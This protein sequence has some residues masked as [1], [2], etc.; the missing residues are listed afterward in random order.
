MVT[1]LDAVDRELSAIGAA[2]G[3]ELFELTQEIWKLLTH[4][5]PE[6]RGDELVGRLLDASIEENVSTLLH[7]F[8]HGTPAD[9]ADAPAGPSSTPAGWLSAGSPSSR[10]SARTASGTAASSPGA[11]RRSPSPSEI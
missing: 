2:A 7:V 11:W 10:S 3:A 9:Q 1:S 5:I 8:E 6:L 4:D